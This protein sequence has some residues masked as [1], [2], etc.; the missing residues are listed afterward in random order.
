M[1]VMISEVVIMAS[2][3]RS[4]SRRISIKTSATPSSSKSNQSVLTEQN[5]SQEEIPPKHNIFE[6]EV[7]FEDIN[8]AI[9]NWEIPKSLRMNYTSLKSLNWLVVLTS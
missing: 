5:T 4:L 8:Q 2:L 3:L 9:D 6:E 1:M 7:C